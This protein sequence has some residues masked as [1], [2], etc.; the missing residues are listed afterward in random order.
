MTRQGIGYRIGRAGLVN[1]LVLKT[2]KFGVHLELPL[3]LQALI[4]NVHEATLVGEDCKFAMLE[5]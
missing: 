2:G 3:S 4:S 1:D 5:V